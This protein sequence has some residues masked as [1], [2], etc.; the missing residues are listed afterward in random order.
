MLV[1]RGND[2]CTEVVIILF[3]RFGELPIRIHSIRRSRVLVYDLL[4][5]SLGVRMIFQ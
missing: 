4:N 2:I 1:R 3:L 5:V